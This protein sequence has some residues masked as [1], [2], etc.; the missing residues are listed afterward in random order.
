MV[1]ET[2]PS[3]A[4]RELHATSKHVRRAAAE[5]WA[6]QA[7]VEQVRDATTDWGD[8]PVVVLQAG[9]EGWPET[10]SDSERA[11]ADRVWTAVQKEL[12]SRSSRSRYLVVHESGHGIPWEAP[13][14]V[15]DELQELVQSLRDS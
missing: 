13:Q 10:Y 6:I 7:S 1:P 5:W 12:A 9:S 8:T 11:Q 4:A 14:V 15:I 2:D 3:W